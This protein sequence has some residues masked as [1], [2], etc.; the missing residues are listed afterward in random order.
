MNRIPFAALFSA[1][2]LATLTS[3]A[4]QEL[5]IEGEIVM[6]YANAPDK[7]LIDHPVFLMADTAVARGLEQWRAGFKEELKIIDSAEQRIQF[8][9]D[10]LRKAIANAG[11]NTEALEK[12]FKAYNDTLNLFYLTANKYKG[13]VLKTL[14]LRLPKIKGIKTDQQG[15]FRFDT[16]TLG[17]PLMPGKYVLMSGYDAERQSGILFQTVELTDKPIRTQLTVRDIDPVLNFYV[18][19]GKEGVAVQK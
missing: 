10:S 18:E 4:K 15:K 6:S 17:A 2:L 3:C 13:D 8:T 14:I 5:F 19:R 7:V 12:A 11:K 16:K 9:I 1:L